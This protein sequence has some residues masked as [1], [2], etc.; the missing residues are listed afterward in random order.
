MV[1]T[2]SASASADQQGC[3]RHTLPGPVGVCQVLSLPA[4]CRAA[5][6]YLRG[7]RGYQGL[8]VPALG[9]EVKVAAPAQPGRAGRAAGYVQEGLGAGAAPGP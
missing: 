5:A 1:P 9:A 2:A 4:L 7:R 3:S 6:D 8:E